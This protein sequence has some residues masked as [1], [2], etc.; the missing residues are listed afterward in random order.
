MVKDLRFRQIHLDFHTSENIPGIGKQFDKKDF[1]QTLLDAHVDSITC[2]SSCHHGWSYHPTKVGKMH[3]NLDFDLLGAQI[4]A[5]KEVDINVP[6]YLTAG[7]NNVA[8]DEH[9]DWREIDHNGQY[10]G[11]AKSILEP[12]FKMLCF[13]SPYIEHLCEMI[14]EALERYPNC[15]GIF[16]DIINQGKCYCKYCMEVMEKNGLDPANEHDSQKCSELALERYY[17]MTT[18]TVRN[19]DSKMPIFHN[20]G[21]IRKDKPQL[22]DYFSHLEMESLPTGGWGY[23][24]FPMSAKYAMNGKHQYLGMTGKFNTTWGEFGG[25]KHPNAL[26]YETAA[27]LAFN[28]RCSVG[29]QL[30]PSGKIDKSTYDLIGKAYEQVEK[31][32]AWCKDTKNVAEIALINE[33][34]TNKLAFNSRS[35]SGADTG[36][37]RILLESHYLFDS[38]NDQTDISPYKLVILPDNINVSE[39]FKTKID[40][41]LQSGG[42]IILT[43]QSGF[44]NDNKPLF[45]I[46]AECSQTSEF[47]PDYILLNDDIS[48][49]F[50]KTP[51]V[52]Y[53]KSK[54]IKVTNGKSIGKVYD[55]YFNREAKHF[56][57]H[58]H[59]PY[60]TEDSGFDCGVLNG[61]ILYLA[62]PVFSIYRWYGA[63]A[64]KQYVCNCI[65]MLLNG[66]KS[67]K[68]NLPSSAR[69]S[70]MDQ[71]E[72]NR[73]VLHLLYA[74]K[75]C[76]GGA[77][78]FEG[79]NIRAT[80]QIEIIEDLNPLYNV[81]VE[82]KTD[83]QV[84]S[85][86]LQPENKQIDAV[87]ENGKV[88]FKLDSFTCH[89]MIE[90][91]Y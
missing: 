27:M 84:K 38:I 7:V 9:P 12:G 57:S 54:R 51:L 1:Q 45:D 91:N 59:T 49:D 76:R 5:C 30:H 21:H 46:G 70:L 20:S 87:I 18:E 24:H 80:G 74:E 72:N 42:K 23:D 48:P 90:M 71:S 50:V 13:N 35:D 41:Y 81:E 77:M 19:F 26:I 33:E 65:D 10:L 89:A 55:P 17:K 47:C 52:M 16:L 36:A 25:F 85:V 60:K 8:A 82:L 83:K 62:H 69:V 53:M 78:Q 86:F 34:A 14:T 58:Q 40:A 64:Y 39:K 79:G 68:T 66:D 28:S 73:L 63:V 11:W 6:V 22:L 75:S 67:F 88:K 37:A 61:N 56:C 44:S 32:E 2:F 29:D 43:G 4:D 15:D 31:K 3:P